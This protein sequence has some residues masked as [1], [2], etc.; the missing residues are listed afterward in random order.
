MRL[1]KGFPTKIW[2]LRG[3]TDFEENRQA[4]ERLKG[5]GQPQSVRCKDNIELSEQLTLIQ[6]SHIRTQ[7]N[8]ECGHTKH[9]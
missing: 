2:S 4:I 3:L 9:S 1:W 5:A 7:P 6:E 8:I